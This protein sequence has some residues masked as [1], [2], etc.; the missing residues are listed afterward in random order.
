[1]ISQLCTENRHEQGALIL[2]VN[3]RGWA[4]HLPGQQVGPECACPCHA[5][6]AA[7]LRLDGQTWLAA[8][9]ANNAAP[10]VPGLR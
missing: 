8:G 6:H 3:C 7:Q 9:G 4:F 2:V 1:V 10:S 5:M